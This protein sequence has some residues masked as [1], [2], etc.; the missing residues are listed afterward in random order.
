MRY[1]IC[2]NGVTINYIEAEE[3]FVSAYCRDSGYTY[4]ES[5]LPEPILPEPEPTTDE[6][7]NILLGVNDNG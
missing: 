3:S 2:E 1:E 5:P 7:L 4:A 6:L